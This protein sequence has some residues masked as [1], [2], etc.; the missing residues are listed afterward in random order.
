M[1][2]A[3]IKRRCRM[4]LVVSTYVHRERRIYML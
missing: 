2:Q 3:L 1:I 4:E